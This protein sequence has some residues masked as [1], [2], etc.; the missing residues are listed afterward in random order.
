MLAKA[1]EFKCNE[2][3]IKCLC[4]NPNF[5]YGIHDCVLSACKGDLTVS[6][7]LIDW[8]IKTCKD[9]GV[10]LTIPAATVPVSELFFVAG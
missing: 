6:Q 7:D 5:G 1:K 4:A 2:G 3:D 9:N 8:G 10:D